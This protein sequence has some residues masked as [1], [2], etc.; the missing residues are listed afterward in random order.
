[1][2]LLWLR[3][4]AWVVLVSWYAR[5]S[6]S[7]LFQKKK[8]KKPHEIFHGTICTSSMRSYTFWNHPFHS[9]Q[10]FVIYIKVQ[11][12]KRPTSW[13]ERHANIILSM[14]LS[15]LYSNNS[16]IATHDPKYLRKAAELRAATIVLAMAIA[17]SSTSHCGHG[18][19]GQTI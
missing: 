18:L 9:I 3:L 4:G 15:S 12:R 5:D 10:T 17:P 7:S 2:R 19:S 16:I 13:R 11:Y 14:T 8:K 6:T 1:V